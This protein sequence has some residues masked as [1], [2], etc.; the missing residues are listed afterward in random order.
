[1]SQ[2]DDIMTELY[3]AKKQNSRTPKSL[4]TYLNFLQ[5]KDQAQ[6]K[7]TKRKKVQAKH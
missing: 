7:L 1:M 6:M 4:T 5:K 3:A 2:F